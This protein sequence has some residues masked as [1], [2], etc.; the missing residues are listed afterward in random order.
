MASCC[1]A[2]DE[3]EAE[4][5]GRLAAESEVRASEIRSLFTPGEAGDGLED[6][7]APYPGGKREEARGDVEARR[8][9]LEHLNPFG[10]DARDPPPSSLAVDWAFTSAYAAMILA[11]AAITITDFLGREAVSSTRLA[12]WSEGSCVLS[13]SCREIAKHRSWRSR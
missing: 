4:A 2:P 5:A 6:A 10:V 11:F 9:P 7:S 12:A 8:T 13:K 3:P 1:G